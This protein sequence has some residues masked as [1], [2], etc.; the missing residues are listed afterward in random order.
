MN[1]ERRQHGAGLGTDTATS[2][3]YIAVTGGVLNSGYCGYKCYLDS[4]E[5]L[6]LGDTEWK[7]GKQ[8]LFHNMG[9]AIDTFL[10]Y[11]RPEYAK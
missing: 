6:F 4:V 5:I 7:T 1:Q 11:F 8:H 3:L 2:E 10:K 9:K